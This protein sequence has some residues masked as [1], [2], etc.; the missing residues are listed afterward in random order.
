MMKVLLIDEHPLVLSALESA[1]REVGED[2]TVVGV[3]HLPDALK[4]LQRESGFELALLGVSLAD[5]SGFDEL[6]TLRRRHPGLPVV[7]LSEGERPA[8]VIRAVDMGAM[9][10]VPRGSG[11]GDLR[12]ALA[13]VMCGG[14]YV[15][16]ALLGLV[17]RSEPAEG[18]DTVPSVMRPGGDAGRVPELDLSTDAAPL[19]EAPA[20]PPPDAV[21]AR[22]R[23][24]AGLESLGL[25][26]R[27]ADVLALLLRGLPN[28]LIARELNLSVDTVKDH[29]AA[30]LRALNVATRTQAV[31][32]V[33]QMTMANSL[34]GWGPR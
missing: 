9:G 1:V 4:L 18:G 7:L 3:D 16:P 12:T 6:G 17:R 8:E 21:P 33:S 11:L 26:A 2:I 30:V 28:K 34:P 32:A 25:T 27:Q 19:D 14:I 23:T 5:G 13:M 10:Y 22:G 15:P 20:V 31:L 24:P 29:V